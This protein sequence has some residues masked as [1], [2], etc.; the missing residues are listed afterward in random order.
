MPSSFKIAVMYTGH[1]W[2]LPSAILDMNIFDY[3]KKTVSALLCCFAVSAMHINKKIESDK[4]LLIIF[5]AQIRQVFQPNIQCDVWK[6]HNVDWWVKTTHKDPIAAEICTTYSFVWL[7][8]CTI[9]IFCRKT[10]LPEG[11]L[12]AH[13]V[14]RLS[15]CLRENYLWR[16]H[17]HQSSAFQ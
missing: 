7:Y 5:A 15:G 16:W 6:Q 8:L 3:S 11:S 12:P 14:P 10:F 13:C 1:N 4:N 9:V 2:K 17:L